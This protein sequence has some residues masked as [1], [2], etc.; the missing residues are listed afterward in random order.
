[1]MELFGLDVGEPELVFMTTGLINFKHSDRR[2]QTLTQY[3]ANQ[4][5][6]LQ[7]IKMGISGFQLTEEVLIFS[8]L[9]LKKYLISKM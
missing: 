8:I 7:K 3:Q 6:V 5:Q 9:K 2:N 1:M 4:L